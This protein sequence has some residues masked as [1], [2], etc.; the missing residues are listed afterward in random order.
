[1]YTPNIHL[2]H[3]NT[4]YALNTPYNNI[5]NRYQK[6]YVAGQHRVRYDDGDIRVY[7]LSGK[8]YKWL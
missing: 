3:S 4:P 8:E 7:K 1:M 6:E 2:T 5:L